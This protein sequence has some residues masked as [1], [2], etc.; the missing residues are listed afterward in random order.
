MQH[1][2]LSLSQDRLLRNDL[3]RQL[4]LILTDNKLF[5]N[6]SFDVRCCMD[7]R[8]A[9]LWRPYSQGH[10][11]TELHL[12]KCLHGTETTSSMLLKTDEDMRAFLSSSI[13]NVFEQAFRVCH[14]KLDNGCPTG[15]VRVQLQIEGLC[16]LQQLLIV[17]FQ[18]FIS[19]SSVC[20]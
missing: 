2:T 7:L 20:Q 12:L 14:L 17:D 5:L 16:G 3:A 9:P 13:G 4:R 11:S 10:S 6:E 18:Q 1:A 19:L 15:P 8:P